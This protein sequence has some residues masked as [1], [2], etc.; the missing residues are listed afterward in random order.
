MTTYHYIEPATLASWL[1]DGAEIALIDV[2]EEG[3]FGAG[4][5]LLACNVPYSRL[6]LDFPALVPRRAT[7]VVLIGEE[8]PDGRS[9][10]ERAAERLAA[11]GYTGVQLLAGG[12]AAWQ[13]AGQPLF[14]GIYVPSKAFAECV[15]LAFHTP[16]IE[17]AE[18]HRLQQQGADLIV[19][20]SRTTAEYA[21]YHV[22]GAISCPGAE[23]VLRFD[24]LVKSPAT[25]VVVSC[26][27]RTRGIIGAQALIN[28]GVPNPV[29]ALQGGTQDWKLAGLAIESGATA[30]HGALGE[31][32]HAAA[33]VRGDD[34]ARRF[35]VP[36]IS[37][38][39]LHA[40]QADDGRTTYLF[41]VRSPAEYGA[42]RLP[43]ATGVAGGQLVQTLDKWV[44]T[45]G[46]RV[47][48]ADDLGVRAQVTAHWLRQLGWDAVVL[49][50]APDQAI[51][52]AADN[53]APA[54]AISAEEALALLAAGAAGISVDASAD[55]R[56]AH[57]RGA[58]WSN[59][60]RIDALPQAVR[61]AKALL[62]F[63]ADGGV[64]QLYAR[65]LAQAV[66]GRVQVVTG[67]AAQWRAAGIALDSTPEL[68]ADAQRIDF[69]FWLHDRHTGNSAASR[70][71][72]AW[73][74][75]LPQAIGSPAQ[76]G[77]RLTPH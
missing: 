26:A 32:A 51:A 31:A 52:V 10:A 7:R 72:L 55:Y 58:V 56:A 14:Q 71:Y 43:G 53:A 61:D 41:D 68:P 18:L 60:S 47:V 9:T 70:A 1:E 49:R 19:L 45:R 69:L 27:G 76:A 38:E 63:A 34:L 74:A 67:G 35:D 17:A 25:Q 59:R 64:A 30:V 28:A 50:H 29:R 46:A 44:A 4:H 21:R 33:R 22:P 65:D 48:L 57:P 15:E 5:A 36:E 42:A 3:L 73:E 23:L 13:A 54:A 77:F 8:R 75:Q 16:T 62:V 24:D 40:W 20:D 66:A 12:S 6:E 2:R 37:L 39:Q 11:L